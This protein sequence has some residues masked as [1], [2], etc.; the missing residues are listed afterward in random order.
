[1]W[2]ISVSRSHVI[3][4]QKEW[5]IQVTSAV[6]D[7]SGFPRGRL[8]R[9]SP[10]ITTA[11]KTLIHNHLVQK[12]YVSRKSLW[13][14]Y[15]LYSLFWRRS[16]KKFFSKKY[17]KVLWNFFIS[18]TSME[19]VFCVIPYVDTVRTRWIFRATVRVVFFIRLLQKCITL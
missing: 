6:S 3:N 5:R 18:M 13:I 2:A 15:M 1:M 7:G 19:M 8:F 17:S 12:I 16:S 9:T 4:W 14:Y 11:V 10:E